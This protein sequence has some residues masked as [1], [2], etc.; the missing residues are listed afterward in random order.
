MFMSADSVSFSR[1]IVCGG[2]FL[3]YFHAIW[4]GN[5]LGGCENRLCF[6][7]LRLVCD[8]QLT[9]L[10]RSTDSPRTSAKDEKTLEP[11]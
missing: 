10:T 8:S 6:S 2:S 7:F 9:K 4:L 1:K 11:W 3:F 5:F